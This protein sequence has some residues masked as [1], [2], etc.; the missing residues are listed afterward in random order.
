MVVSKSHLSAFT[1][2]PLLN[3]HS[4]YFSIKRGLKLLKEKALEM[5]P[6]NGRTEAQTWPQDS[7]K[8]NNI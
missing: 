3:S 1:D 4:P 2:V 8:N 6:K 7:E 5:I